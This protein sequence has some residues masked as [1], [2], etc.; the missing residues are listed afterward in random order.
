LLPLSI[1]F[2]ILYGSIYRSNIFGTKFAAGRCS[3]K[4]RE[5]AKIPPNQNVVYFCF[6]AEPALRFREGRAEGAAAALE[7][8]DRG[9]FKAA[10]LPGFTTRTFPSLT[11]CCTNEIVRRRKQRK[12]TTTKHANCHLPY[13]KVVKFLHRSKSLLASLSFHRRKAFHLIFFVRWVE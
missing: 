10:S 13:G 7:S 8:F 9:A 1:F 3:E 11:Q 4:S 5:K 12:M 6:L 2:L